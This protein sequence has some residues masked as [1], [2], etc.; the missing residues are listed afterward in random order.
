M[1]ATVP[2][3]AAGIVLAVACMGNSCFPDG[4]T[5]GG[6]YV[7]LGTPQLEVT[8]DGVHVGPAAVVAGSYASLVTQRDS[9][10]QASQA[11]LLLHAVAPSASFDLRVSRFGTNTA[12][13][14]ARPYR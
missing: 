8:V 5:D 10:G 3:R 13:I 7:G 1:A 14:V 9:L 12:Q 2:L 6:G 11:D 4:G